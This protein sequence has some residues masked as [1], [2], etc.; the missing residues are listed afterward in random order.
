MSACPARSV[1]TPEVVQT[2]I[3]DFAF[4]KNSRRFC[5]CLVE[6]YSIKELHLTLAFAICKY[7]A[8]SMKKFASG[9]RE[10]R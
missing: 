4:L 6:K 5:F 10:R 3:F 8:C 1:Q 9:R 2:L 7:Y